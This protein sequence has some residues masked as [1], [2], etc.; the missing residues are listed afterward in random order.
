MVKTSNHIYEN[1]LKN[2]QSWLH[3][4]AAI[5]PYNHDHALFDMI[6]HII[7]TI[8]QYQIAEFSTELIKLITI[9]PNIIRGSRS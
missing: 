6:L 2:Y 8:N 3:K 5:L 7:A 4:V 1:Q 9:I